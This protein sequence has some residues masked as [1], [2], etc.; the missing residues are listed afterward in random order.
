MNPVPMGPTDPARTSGDKPNTALPVDCAK[1]HPG[2]YHSSLVTLF[3]ASHICLEVLDTSSKR[4]NS[5]GIFSPF[6]AE[7][8]SPFNPS[9]KT[10]GG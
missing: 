8:F 1:E 10:R 5:D 4:K 7:R 9:I 3:N 6:S 2:S